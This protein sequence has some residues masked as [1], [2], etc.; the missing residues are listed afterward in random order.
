MSTNIYLSNPASYQG[1]EIY[2]TANY[3]YSGASVSDAGDVNG[4]G[5]NDIII[6]PPKQMMKEAFQEQVMWFLAKIQVLVIFIYLA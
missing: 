6:G 4:D 3:D 1:F 5:Y 2:G